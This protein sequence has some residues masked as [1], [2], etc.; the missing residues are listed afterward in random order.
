MKIFILSADSARE[1]FR[2]RTSAGVRPGP[3]PS[4]ARLRRPPRPGPGGSGLGRAGRGEKRQEQG[5]AMRGG[6][7]G[8]SGGEPTPP[9][10]FRRLF[11]FTRKLWAAWKLSGRQRRGRGGGGEWGRGG[12]HPISARGGS[13]R[14]G[15]VSFRCNP[16]RF[17][18]NEAAP[19]SCGASRAGAGRS[20]VPH[21][22]RPGTR[23]GS[24]PL[25]APPEHHR[26]S[27]GASFSRNLFSKV[28]RRAALNFT[29]WQR[30]G[31]G[32]TP[33][34]LSGEKRGKISGISPGCEI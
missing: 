7:E 12:F 30:H 14:T 4:P 22:P 26:G 32:S 9:R 24:P 8:G 29:P 3:A 5:E 1:V 11:S 33:S 34:E 13:L 15:R 25:P 2:D 27:P 6:R 16:R 31:Q 20:R 28:P 23:P 17:S 19:R 18:P 10:P 21:P